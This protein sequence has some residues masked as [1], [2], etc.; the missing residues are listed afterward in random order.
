[1]SDKELTGVAAGREA[2]DLENIPA[3]LQLR[4]VPED[5]IVRRWYALHAHSGQEG[6]VRTTQSVKPV[7]QAGAGWGHQ[8][9]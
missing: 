9:C 7:T 1:M 3:G 4:E 2:E 8:R 6:S 5:G